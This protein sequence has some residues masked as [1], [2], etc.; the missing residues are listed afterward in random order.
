MS[1][2][3]HTVT[4]HCVT[5]NIHRVHELLLKEN[6]FEDHGDQNQ[7]SGA[8]KQQENNVYTDRSLWRIRNLQILKNVICNVAAVYECVCVC[9]CVIDGEDNASFSTGWT[10]KMELLTP[11]NPTPESFVINE[12]FHGV[13]V[14]DFSSPRVGPPPPTQPSCRG[15]SD[16]IWGNLSEAWR[17]LMRRSN[18]TASFIV[19]F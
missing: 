14:H 2:Q 5:N 17:Y 7:P 3:L 15:P 13:S 4:L 9:V 11:K 1:K 6:R 10:A 8:E 18:A 12:S 19:C 16:S